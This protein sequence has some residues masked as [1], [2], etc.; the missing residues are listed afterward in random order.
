[1]VDV[2]LLQGHVF[3]AAICEFSCLNGGTCIAPNECACME[4]F[5]GLNCSDSKFV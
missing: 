1:M 3:F 4:T 5:G 2:L